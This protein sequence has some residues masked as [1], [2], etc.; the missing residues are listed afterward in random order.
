MKHLNLL[1]GILIVITIL[2]CSS[3]DSN[4][5]DNNLKKI[6]SLQIM[7]N[8]NLVGQY[9]FKYENKRLA[10]ITVVGNER[11]VFSYSDDRIVLA[12]EFNFTGSEYNQLD[13][14]TNYTFKMDFWFQT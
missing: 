13:K 10:S 6:T 2:S 4:S 7:E 11:I 5:N 12:E 9:D 3:D 1:I 8:G 14:T